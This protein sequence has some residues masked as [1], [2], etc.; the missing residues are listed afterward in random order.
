MVNELNSAK[1]L[2]LKHFEHEIE[3]LMHILSLNIKGG[4][5]GIPRFSQIILMKQKR[6]PQNW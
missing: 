1:R 5:Q 6:L 3:I 4:F 2:I